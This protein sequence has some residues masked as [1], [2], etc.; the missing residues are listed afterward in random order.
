MRDIFSQEYH[1][2]SNTS[3][4]HYILL[5]GAALRRWVKEIDYFS[6]TTHKPCTI[7]STAV[8]EYLSS[9]TYHQDITLISKP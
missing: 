2:Q 4:L 8:S 7:E 9:K 5:S 1:R 3:S 6:H